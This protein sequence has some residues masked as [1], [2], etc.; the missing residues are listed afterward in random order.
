M[1]KKEEKYVYKKALV[2]YE[3][4][5]NLHKI[6]PSPAFRYHNKETQ[7][8]LPLFPSGSSRDLLA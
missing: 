2:S 5:I 4:L 6:S 7:I 3:Y 8:A 1:L